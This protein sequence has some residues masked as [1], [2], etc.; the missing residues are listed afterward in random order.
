MKTAREGSES[1]SEVIRS[2]A[3]FTGSLEVA[4]DA[5]SRGRFL[6]GTHL[7]TLL[8]PF[9][10]WLIRHTPVWV[11][12]LPVRLIVSPMR[13]LY[14]WRNNPLRLS[15]EYVCRLAAG[16]GY[17]HEPAQVYQRYLTNVLAMA[18]NYFRLYRH[19]VEAVVDRVVIR[20][21]DSTRINE[22]R[23]A[24]GGLILTAPHNLGSAFSALQ[25]N[26]KFPILAVARNPSTVARTRAALDMFERMEIKTLMVRGGNPFEMSRSMFAA[27]KDGRVICAT[28]D[29]I[30]NSEQGVAA[31]IFGQRI[32]FPSWAARIATRRRIPMVPSYFRQ[33]GTTIRAVYGEALITDDL[34]K[35]VAHSVA[36]FERSIYEDPASWAYLGDR[37]WRRV[38]SDAAEA[39]SADR[40][41]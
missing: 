11:S 40:N 4:E 36:F 1:R 10:Y 6:S 25:M 7:K 28:V 20:E 35:I 34:T 23:D 9:F 27:L 17:R 24:H 39:L 38:L 12:L 31:T 13:L 29:N 21:P 16:A 22:L 41:D 2:P 37:R 8:I 19:R 14:G 33:E 15:C 5:G 3:L 26:R 30:D 18:D 32:G